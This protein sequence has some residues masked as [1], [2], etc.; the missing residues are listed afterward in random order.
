MLSF[1]PRASISVGREAFDVRSAP[2]TNAASSA[3]VTLGLYAPL[4]VHV[5]THAFAGFGP[6]ISHDAIRRTDDRPGDTLATR[7]GAS[8]LVGGWL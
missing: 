1:Y 7:I 5:A 8:L 4:L 6:Y 3:V 2:Q